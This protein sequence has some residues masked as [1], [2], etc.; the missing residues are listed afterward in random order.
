LSILFELAK[1]MADCS[2][3]RASLHRH[4]P[5]SQPSTLYIKSEPFPLFPTE[6]TL[7][8]V[9]YRNPPLAHTHITP[10]L[11]SRIG[12]LPAKNKTNQN[13]PS[14]IYTLVFLSTFRSGSPSL[15]L[16]LTLSSPL[17]T[18]TRAPSPALGTTHVPSFRLAAGCFSPVAAACASSMWSRN[19][20]LGAAVMSHSWRVPATK[21]TR[22]AVVSWWLGSEGEVTEGG[23][24]VCRKRDGV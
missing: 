10:P 14:N 21:A 4:I 11:H 6:T 24:G 19:D 22:R 2:S 12:P 13:K 9:F 5:P 1:G 7:V 20:F 17:G 18:L 3:T 23:G 15:R 8:S 16:I